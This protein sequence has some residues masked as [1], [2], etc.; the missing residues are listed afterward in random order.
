MFTT[1][2]LQIT[3]LSLCRCTQSHDDTPIKP[4]MMTSVD[5]NARQQRYFGHTSEE[6]FF[7][8]IHLP[9]LALPNEVVTMQQEQRESDVIDFLRFRGLQSDRERAGT[10]TVALGRKL[11]S[12][13]FPSLSPLK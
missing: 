10:C 4:Q 6:F 2:P 9:E 8:F 11:Y 7:F 12:Q 1:W 3:F 13:L 5:S